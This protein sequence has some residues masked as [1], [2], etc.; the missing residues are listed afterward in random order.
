MN[1]IY[2]KNSKNKNKNFETID[3]Y[4]GFTSVKKRKLNVINEE[5]EF[6]LSK[7]LISSEI[8]DESLPNFNEMF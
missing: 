3:E 4:L 6:S 5:D 7:L 2:N 8:K 1:L